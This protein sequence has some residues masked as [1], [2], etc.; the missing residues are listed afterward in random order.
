MISKRVSNIIFKSI[1]HK[2]IRYLQPIKYSA[3]VGD[4]KRI[5][6]DIGY[7]YVLGAPFTLHASNPEI[8][9]G[10]WSLVRESLIVNG[11]VKRLTKEAIAGGVSISNQ[12]PYCHEAHIK[13]SGGIIDE[14]NE[15]LFEW[16]KSHYKH[17]EIILNPPFS[18]KEAPEI[19][20]TAL[21]FHYIN[22]MVNVF[23][24]EYPLPLPRYLNWLKPTISSFFKNTAAANITSIKALPGQSLKWLTPN[25]ETTEFLWT[26]SNIHIKNSFLSFDKL[27]N[28]TGENVIPSNVRRIVL[29][30]LADW[31]GNN[32]GF[33][34]EWID[35]LTKGLI[36]SEKVIAQFILLIATMPYKIM[37]HHIHELKKIG[38]ENEKL[39]TIASW[40]SWQA[41]KKIGN[42]I[43]SPFSIGH[44]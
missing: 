2:T 24:T 31:T 29:N 17:N 4:V 14:K 10:I 7:D 25:E 40:G 42:W 21:T 1:G 38:V 33:G 35:N 44:Q 19:I 16:C 23:V 30:Y 39:L 18:I 27:I 36:L 3:S 43:S 13:M 8:M 20:G 22:R 9:A 34:N 28:H 41:T 12:C 26:E 6:D 11:K 37:N 5:Y 32:P 15:N